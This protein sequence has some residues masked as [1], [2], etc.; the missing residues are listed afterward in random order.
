MSVN[1]MDTSSNRLMRGTLGTMLRRTLPFSIVH[2]RAVTFA[3]PTVYVATD[4]GVAYS[5]DGTDWHATTDTEGTPIVIERFAV[6][7]TT[8]YGTSEQRVYQFKENSGVWQQVTPEV[9]S[10]VT[11]LAVNGSVLYVGTAGSGVLRFTLDESP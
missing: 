3:G 6:D 7:G 11:S 1:G 8:V 10:T 5:S 9:P 2:F 4:K